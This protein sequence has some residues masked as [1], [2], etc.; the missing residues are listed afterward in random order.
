MDI[1][2]QNLDAKESVMIQVSWAS[3]SKVLSPLSFNFLFHGSAL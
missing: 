1:R 3:F 2:E